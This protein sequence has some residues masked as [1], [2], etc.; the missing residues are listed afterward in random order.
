MCSII[1]GKVKTFDD[2]TLNLTD[3]ARGN[4]SVLLAADC[5][6]HPNFA[7]FIKPLALQSEVESFA[8]ELYVD[9]DTVVYTPRADHSDWI[10]LNGQ[11]ESEIVTEVE[12]LPERLKYTTGGW[13]E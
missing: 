4:C 8:L 13:R 7:L 2:A 10:S 6:A 9:D 5:S 11:A 3:F 1:A 12:P